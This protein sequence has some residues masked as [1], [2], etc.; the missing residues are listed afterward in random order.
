MKRKL[1]NSSFFITNTNGCTSRKELEKYDLKED[2]HKMKFDFLKETTKVI[3]N[4]LI[5]KIITRSDIS[6]SEDH[7]FRFENNETFEEL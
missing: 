3:Y 6:R 4:N 7:D 5:I 2:C 1:F